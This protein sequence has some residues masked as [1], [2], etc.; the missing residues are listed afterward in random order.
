MSEMGWGKGEV[1]IELT[2]KQGHVRTYVRMLVVLWGDATR[3][4][5]WMR[6]A[7]NTDRFN[8][9]A[10]CSP[11]ATLLLAFSLSREM[12]FA[13]VMDFSKLPKNVLYIYLI[14]FYYVCLVWSCETVNL[15]TRSSSSFSRKR[16]WWKFV[17]NENF[18][19]N[20]T[21]AIKLSQGPLQ[22]FKFLSAFLPPPSSKTWK[23]NSA[24]GGEALTGLSQLSIIFWFTYILSSCSSAGEAGRFNVYTQWLCVCVNFAAGL[25]GPRG[26]LTPTAAALARA[27]VTR[28][29]E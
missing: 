25:T 4:C 5:G 8:Y 20:K 17:N 28:I 15:I 22:H 27:A 23:S 14:V 3:G 7:S 9:E 12:P 18:N 13:R 19:R 6:P 10:P 2:Q 16:Q 24:P 29:K 11:G 26:K 21:L 1:V